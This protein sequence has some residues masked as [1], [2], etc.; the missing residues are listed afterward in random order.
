MYPNA[1]MVGTDAVMNTP[2][3]YKS[4]GFSALIVVV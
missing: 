1:S 3:I 2:P 4:F